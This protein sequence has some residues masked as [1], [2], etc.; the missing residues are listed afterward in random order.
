M[1]LC[2]A[3]F[4]WSDPA[5]AKVRSASIT[6]DDVRIWDRMVG[7]H[8]SIPHRRVCITHRPDL[9]DFMETVPI[10]CTKHVPGTCLVKL[11]VHRPDIGEILKAE[12]ILLM[13]IDCV[14]TGN[15]DE[16]VS[17]PEPFAG[18]R[19][20]NYEKGG[21]RGFFQ[22]SLQLF[23]AGAK[24]ELWRDF[25]PLRTPG[26]LN[27]RFGGAEQCWI[28]ERLNASYPD[29]GWEW[30]DPYFTE[31]D[32]VYGAGRLFGGKM[33][34]GIQSDLPE[35]ARVVFF[36]GDRSPSQPEVQASHP[37]VKEHYR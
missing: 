3:S 28:S 14:V 1:T 37:W 8:I 16:I 12:R 30:S 36:P 2:V 17:R 27:R 32:G 24:S 7:R 9:I 11:M 21:R 31:A 34:K 6:S 23:T 26:W 18:W 19:N 33:G 5:R 20:P 25:D 29:P 22:G 35:N 13:D 10:D 4:F 15:L